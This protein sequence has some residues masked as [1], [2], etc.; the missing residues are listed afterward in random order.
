MTTA[1]IIA[2]TIGQWLGYVVVLGGVIWAINTAIK[3]A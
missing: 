3:E 1:G 2:Y